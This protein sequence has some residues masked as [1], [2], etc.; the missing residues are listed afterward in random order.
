MPVVQSLAFSKRVTWRQPLTFIVATALSTILAIWA[1]IAVPI[2]SSPVP[3][4]SGLYIAAAIYV[5]LALW[6]GMWGCLAGY[7]SCLFMGLFLGYGFDFVLVWSL[8]DFF[9]GFVPLLIYRSLK[10]KP[11]L[12]L[13]RPKV[14][15]AL[16]SLL[17]LTVIISGI[18]LIL[19]LTLVFIATFI[20]A[21][22]FLVVLAGAE[23]HKTWTSWLL[24][25]VVFASIVSGVFGVGALAAFHK[26]PMSAFPTVFFGWIFGDIIVL[27]TIGTILMTTLTPYIMKTG[28]YVKGY[29]S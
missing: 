22:V 26:I 7:F 4:V 12:N 14:T 28:A 24:V 8:A 11:V 2:G 9:E 25:G 29:F 23:E 15:H 27:A 20:A 21:I 10:I 5:P 18:A 13:K 6:F 1:V 16:N 19:S 3:G 17:A